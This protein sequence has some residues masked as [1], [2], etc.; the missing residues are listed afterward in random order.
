VPNGI[1]TN[2]L[3]VVVGT[4]MSST[5]SVQTVVKTLPA[6]TM[7][8]FGA[9]SIIGRSVKIT[10]TS[11]NNNNAVQRSTFCGTITL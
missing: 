10:D 2:K 7:T 1:P 9:N 5:N 6:T 4:G 3:N 11:A 8:L